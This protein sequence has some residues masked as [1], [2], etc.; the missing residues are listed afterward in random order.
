MAHQNSD[1]VFETL[2]YNMLIELQEDVAYAQINNNPQHAQIINQS[3][4]DSRPIKLVISDEDKNTLTTIK[5]QDV[6]NKEQHTACFITQEDFKDD[7]DV[8]Q[9]PCLHCFISESIMRWLTE[10]SAECPVCRYKFETKEKKVDSEED[11]D[12]SDLPELVPA[13]DDDEPQSIEENVSSLNSNNIYLNNYSIYNNV[14]YYN[15]DIHSRD[16]I[17]VNNIGWQS[18]YNNFINNTVNDNNPDP[19]PDNN[20]SSMNDVD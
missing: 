14:F 19:D 5:Y 3:L 12:Y 15:Y 17:N 13:S 11:D 2:L 8:I 7:D 9:L 10:E 16:I 20:N 4:Y 18:L 6:V 1:D